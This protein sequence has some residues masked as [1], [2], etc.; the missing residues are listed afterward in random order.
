MK[1][2]QLRPP[3]LELSQFVCSFFFAAVEGLGLGSPLTWSSVCMR[4]FAWRSFFFLM[5]FFA[6]GAAEA[7][8]GGGQA[9]PGVRAENVPGDSGVFCSYG[10]GRLLAGGGEG[11]V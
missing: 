4:L 1:S 7:S 8:A 6:G 9:S 3:T 5:A 10:V 11:G 2:S